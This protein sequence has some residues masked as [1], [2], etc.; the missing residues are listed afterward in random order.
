MFLAVFSKRL[1]HS[2]V[3]TYQCGWWRTA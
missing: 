3:P 1:W 2:Y